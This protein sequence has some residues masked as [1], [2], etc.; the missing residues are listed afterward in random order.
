MNWLKN[1]SLLKILLSCFI[2]LLCISIHAQN[3]VPNPSFEEEIQRKPTDRY[4][5][6]LSP[7]HELVK[8]WVT[9]NSGSSDYYNSNLSTVNNGISV[10]MA[11]SGNGRTGL[12][13]KAS[14]LPGYAEYLQTRLKEPL[15]ANT[16]YQ[17]KFYFS[18]D[19][20]CKIYAS[21]LGVYFSD[22]QFYRTAVTG[23]PDKTPQVLTKDANLLTNKKG[24]SE[25]K[26][27]FVAQG[28]EQYI[29]IG[30]FDTLKGIPVPESANE[31]LIISNRYSFF[32]LYAY[33]YFDDVCI[34]EI[35]NNTPENCC[36][37][38]L[39]KPEP[40]PFN[41]FIFLLDIS[42][43]MEK[44]GFMDD[45]Q[46]VVLLFTDTLAPDDYISVVAY[47][48]RSYYLL[49]QVKAKDKEAIRAVFNK[50]K[51]EKA[52]YF[53]QAIRHTYEIIDSTYLRNGNNQIILATDAIFKIDKS[54]RNLVKHTY[55]EKKISFNTIQFGKAENP[56]L[57]KLCTKT[58]GIYTRANEAH[59]YPE[60]TAK[61]NQTQDPEYTPEIK[62]KKFRSPAASY[63]LLG[64]LVGLIVLVQLN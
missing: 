59:Q 20:R 54:T 63:L 53:D 40:A 21:H 45:L 56:M 38:E 46:N 51:S 35:K 3:L 48:I 16:V 58:K 61:I 13:T 64:L 5:G 42:Q 14:N 15:K 9:P 8:G 18:L 28:G 33:Y 6:I 36:K 2:T 26:T 17:V 34:E 41:N 50:I 52:T 60:L 44:A 11:R 23:F 31:G 47:D 12:V 27:T 49:D 30:N 43:S 1:Y 55:R 19:K 24:W 29:T 22:S 39:Q 62:D 7:Q 10:K 4:N 25:F 57:K 32:P 37:V